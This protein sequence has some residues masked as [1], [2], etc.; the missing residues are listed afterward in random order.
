MTPAHPASFKF[1]NTWR[2][3]K[4][5]QTPP[6]DQIGHD[7]GLSAYNRGYGFNSQSALQVEPPSLSGNIFGNRMIM[8]ILSS[9]HFPSMPAFVVG[10]R[11]AGPASVVSIINIILLRTPAQ[12]FWIAA[13]RVVA[14]VKG[15]R[16]AIR[17]RAIFKKARHLA[18]GVISAAR[19]SVLKFES[20]ISIG[21]SALCHPRPTFIRPAFIDLAPKADDVFLCHIEH[22]LPHSAVSLPL[23]TGGYYR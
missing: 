8:Q 20:A 23:S 1:F 11:L 16:L 18:G 14:G 12:M 5:S 21:V 3:I 13:R 9:R 10:W 19:F 22:G 4:V 2:T 7:M 6:P 15:E 17:S